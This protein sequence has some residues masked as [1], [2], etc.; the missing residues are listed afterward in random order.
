LNLSRWRVTDQLRK[1]LPAVH[2]PASPDD[3]TARTATIEQVPD[4]VGTQLEAL[5]EKEWHTTLLEA[6]LEKV[7]AQ[8]DPRQWQIFDLYVLKD[9]SVREVAKA[10]SVSVGRVYLAKHRVGAL[11]KKELKRLQ[12][13]ME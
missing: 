12:R 11:V 1:R 6:A 10:L 7:K 2:R 3:A 13:K 9:W 5:W 4:P 8:V